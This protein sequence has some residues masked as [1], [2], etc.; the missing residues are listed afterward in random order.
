[1]VQSKTET[2]GGSVS[3][4]LA[5]AAASA[6]ASTSAQNTETGFPGKSPTSYG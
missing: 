5:A 6:M 3:F 1:L 4:A 2:V